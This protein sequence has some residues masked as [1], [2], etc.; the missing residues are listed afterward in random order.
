[1]TT[2]DAKFT[3][4]QGALE[5][6]VVPMPSDVNGGGDIFGG[7]VM[8]QVDIAGGFAA[9]RRARGR[10]ATVAVT[11][12]TFKQPISVGDQVSFY[13]RILHVGRTSITVDVE[14]FAERNP[15]DP[16]WVKVT[17]A[18]LV[19]VALNMDGSKR[20]VPAEPMAA[21]LTHA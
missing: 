16:V 4:P 7:W 8:A 3:P 9:Q 20:V 13:T 2:Q 11:S 17:E 10:V 14:V 21:A 1:M 12:F 18:Q 19:Y 15:E 5:L 6:R